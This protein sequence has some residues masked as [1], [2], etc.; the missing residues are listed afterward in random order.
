M[1]Q[2]KSQANEGSR[3]R[4][5]IPLFVIKIDAQPQRERRRSRRCCSPATHS[6]GNVRDEEE[7]RLR[8][9]SGLAKVR[10]P[11]WKDSRFCPSSMKFLFILWLFN[12]SIGFH[13]TL[14][15]LDLLLLD[16]TQS[17]LSFLA[18]WSQEDTQATVTSM[19]GWQKETRRTREVALNKR[20][21][22]LLPSGRYDNRGGELWCP[23]EA[24]S[25]THFIIRMK[26]LLGFYQYSEDIMMCDAAA[27]IIDVQQHNWHLFWW[28]RLKE[29][30]FHLNLQSLDWHPPTIEW[31]NSRCSLLLGRTEWLAIYCLCAVGGSHLNLCSSIS[32]SNMNSNNNYN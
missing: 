6:L 15:L 19:D 9:Y 28:T 14:V 7:T 8:R 4:I 2:S 10:T 11:H 24:F 3:R 31:N 12:L 13:V 22:Y 21:N 18:S 20:M 30:L 26:L 25:G 1:G 23:C 17:G 5:L 27:E 16:K 29:T 32:M